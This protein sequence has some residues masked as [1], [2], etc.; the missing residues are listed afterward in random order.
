MRFRLVPRPY[1]VLYIGFLYVIVS[2]TRG[3][4]SR[5]K[6]AQIVYRYTYF[7]WSQLA[8]IMLDSMLFLAHRRTCLLSSA[9]IYSQLP[10]TASGSLHLLLSETPVGRPSLVPISKLNAFS[11]SRLIHPLLCG[12]SARLCPMPPPPPPPISTRRDPA[13]FS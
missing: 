9:D 7:P 3:Y 8:T 13:P 12:L 11:F 6:H 1:L 4:S 10:V 5:T 2:A